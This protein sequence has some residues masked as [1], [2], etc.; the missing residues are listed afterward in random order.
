M[1]ARNYDPVSSHIPSSIPI[2]NF[3]IFTCYIDLITIV[4]L[5]V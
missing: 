5:A 4:S 1:M 2:N 3:D